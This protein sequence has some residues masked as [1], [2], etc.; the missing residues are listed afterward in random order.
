MGYMYANVSG[1]V[2]AFIKGGMK[3]M[4]RLKKLSSWLVL[5][6]ILLAGFNVPSV[7]AQ[8]DYT[9]T[10]GKDKVFRTCNIH[11]T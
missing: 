9:I 1:R 7:S 3:K 11:R 8:E 10:V 6:I 5:V 2:G 4:I